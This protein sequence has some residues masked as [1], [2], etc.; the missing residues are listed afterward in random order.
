MIVSHSGSSKDSNISNL[1]GNSLI[2][3]PEDLNNTKRGGSD[4]IGE[5]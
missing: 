3:T 1:I 2:E 5:I 4:G